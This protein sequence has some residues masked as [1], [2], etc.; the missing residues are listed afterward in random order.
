M[1]ANNKAKG[2][3]ITGTDTGVGKTLVAAALTKMLVDKGVQVGVMKPAETGVNQPEQL[4]L[5]GN[6][7]KW[8]AQNQQTDDS[9][10]P[11]RLRAPLAP[12]VAASKERIRIAYSRLVEQAKNT[13]N[14]YDFTIIEGAGG[15]MVPLAGGFLMADYARAVGLPLVVVCRPNLGTINHTLLTLFSAR[16]LDLPVAGYLINNMPS[17][18]TV[19]EETVAHSLASLTTDELLGVLNQ[20]TG[21]AQEKVTQLA[22]QIS[23]LKT[24]SLLARHLP[25]FFSC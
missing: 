10:C 18:Q 19:A 22:E 16:N 5:D 23:R 11:Y 1:S 13:I 4:G 2:L 17:E 12:S 7:L 20:A 25:P 24:Y 15:L 8:A 6:L 21:N 14:E 3:F 9:I